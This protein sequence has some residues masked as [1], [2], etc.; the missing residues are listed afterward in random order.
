MTKSPKFGS[1]RFWKEWHLFGYSGIV[2]HI[3]QMVASN[4][5]TS[6]KAAELIE[7]AVGVKDGTKDPENPPDAPWKEYLERD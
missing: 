5:I 4:H 3:C 1:P 6:R 2:Q 7:Y